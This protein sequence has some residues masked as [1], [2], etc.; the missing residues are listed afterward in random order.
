LATSTP[1]SLLV[2]NEGSFRK[3]A[4]V[5]A[6]C[7]LLEGLRLV[8][9]VAVLGAYL[10]RVQ[11]LLGNPTG[12]ITQGSVLDE[13]TSFHGGSPRCSKSRIEYQRFSRC[14]C[15]GGGLGPDFG[16]LESLTEGGAPLGVI[17]ARVRL[18]ESLSTELVAPSGSL[19]VKASL[20]GREPMK[21]KYHLVFQIT[22]I[23]LL[24]RSKP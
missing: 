20:V 10:I 21:S 7:H 16:L 5:H 19:L 12:A 17:L 4:V 15:K 11:V 14:F 2:V 13:A 6:D 3:D 18:Q 1:C 24:R 9:T 8:E 23:T 22:R